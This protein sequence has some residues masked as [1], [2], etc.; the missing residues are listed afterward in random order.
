VLNE[1]A[2][3]QV[4]SVSV[5]RVWRATTAGLAVAA[6]SSNEKDRAG[7]PAWTGIPDQHAGPGQDWFAASYRG[8]G[9]IN[10]GR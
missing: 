7:E 9:W 2:G 3:L 6:Q 10:K 1:G 8:D 4:G 5:A